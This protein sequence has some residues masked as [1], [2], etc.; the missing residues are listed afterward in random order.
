MLVG[1]VAVV[2]CMF[3]FGLLSNTPIVVGFLASLATF[4]AVSLLTPPSRKMRAWEQ[5]IARPADP[6]RVT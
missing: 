5:R 1:S 2:V 6:E 4:V 3:V